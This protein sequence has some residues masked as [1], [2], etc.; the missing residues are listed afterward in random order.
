MSDISNEIQQTPSRVP[1]QPAKPV[2]TERT[3]L[4]ASCDI[5][6]EC[7]DCGRDAIMEYEGETLK[8]CQYN[9]TVANTVLENLQLEIA[10]YQPK[11]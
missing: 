9:A 2:L 10:A 11:K 7:G 1:V 5:Y 3:V 8:P 4:D 6:A